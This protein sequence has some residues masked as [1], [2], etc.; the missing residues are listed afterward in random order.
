LVWR[1][2]A[3]KSHPAESCERLNGKADMSAAKQCVEVIDTR[4]GAPKRYAA[5]C[6]AV[7]IR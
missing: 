2:A 6:K 3:A 5:E 7:R 4:P 1:T